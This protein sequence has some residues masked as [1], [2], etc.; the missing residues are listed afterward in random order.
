MD[1]LL[2]VKPKFAYEIVSG[3]KR[4]ELRKRIFNTNK[5]NRIYIY[6]SSPEMRII[7]SFKVGTVLRDHPDKLWEMVKNDSG[8][9]YQTYSNYFKGKKEGYAIQIDDLKVLDPP[10]DPREGNPDFIAPQSY[11]YIRT[12]Q[13][14]TQ[15]NECTIFSEYPCK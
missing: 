3:T 13:V 2:S 11:Q 8:I 7:G 10:I 5:V 14:Y 15:K 1:V 12:P 4:Y 9:D 6:S